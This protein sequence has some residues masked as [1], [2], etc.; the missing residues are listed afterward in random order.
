MRT[1][2]NLFS[3]KVV[4]IAVLLLNAALMYGQSPEQVEGPEQSESQTGDL[5]EEITP[6]ERERF[7][8][9]YSQLQE[10]QNELEQNERRIVENSSLTPD[11]FRNMYESYVDNN[12]GVFGM[13]NDAEKQEF[14]E[15]MEKI[16]ELQNNYRRDLS[17]I[18]E[19]SGFSE[20]RFYQ[21]Y[22][23]IEE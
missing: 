5:G 12:Q 19:S 9:A 6:E 21:L 22:Q 13:A 23:N 11:A 7:E 8:T 16:I 14:A 2:H 15:V 10:L 1:Y 17:E 20:R 4:L 18:I 3:L